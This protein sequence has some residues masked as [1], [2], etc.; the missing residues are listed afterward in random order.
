MPMKATGFTDMCET[1]PIVAVDL[2]QTCSACPSQWQG[3]T[4]EGK[5]LYIRFRHGYLAVY[6]DEQ[7]VFDYSDNRLADGYME[8]E[9]MLML[10]GI[11]ST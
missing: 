5:E 3:Y 2:E 6:V 7:V 9:E 1:K 10:T 11:I 4:S 8:T